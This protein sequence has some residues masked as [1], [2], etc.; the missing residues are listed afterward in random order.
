MEKRTLIFISFLII[1]SVFGRSF[2]AKSTSDKRADDNMQ[3]ITLSMQKGTEKKISGTTIKKVKDFEITPTSLV[4]QGS[5]PLQQ[6]DLLIESEDTIDMCILKVF[7]GDELLGGKVLSSIGKGTNRVSVFLP[8]PEK[9]L[10]T[11]WVLSNSSGILF[12]KDLIWNTPRHWTIYVI[13]SSHVDIGLHDPQY[14][15]RHMTSGLIDQAIQLSDNTSHWPDVSRYRYVVEGLWWWLNY[16]QDRSEQ[17]GNKVVEKYI[18]S[19]II[20][21]GAS[22]SGNHTQVYGMEELCRSTY[23]AQ[24]VRNRWGI[25]GE[26]M[27]VADINGIS[28]PLVTAYADAGIKN[29]IFLPNAWNALANPD[30]VKGGVNDSRVTFGAND[31]GVSR[32]AVGWGSKLPH[33]FYWQGANSKSRILVWTN[34][35]YSSTGYDFGVNASSPE[36]GAP[37]MV[38]QLN[39]LESR[40]PYN[41]WLASYYVDN[42]KPNNNFSTLAKEWNARW[43]WP[44]LRT[45]GD[46]SEPF[47]EVEKRSGDKIPTLSGA[48]TG[49]WAQHPVSTPN[50]LATKF[51]AD[52][53]LPTAE[54]LATLARLTNPD[55]IYPTL[56]FRRAWDALVCNDEHGYGTSYYSGRPVYDTWMQKKDWIEQAMATAK[57]E[58]DR[59]LKVL[60]AQVTANTPS[61]FVFNPTLLPRSEI[62]KINIPKSCSGLHSVICPDG[63]SAVTTVDGDKLIFKTSEIPSMGYALFPLSRGDANAVKRQTS[64]KPPYIEN[65]FYRVTFNE[66]GAI[67]SIFDKQLLRELVDKS[68]LYQC[69]QFVYTKDLHKNFSSPSN[70]RFEIETSPLEQTVIAR[71]DDPVSGAAI[72][73]RVTLPAHEKRID[74]DNRLNHVRDLA[75]KERW[76]RFGYYAFPFNVPQGK[77]RIGLNGCNVDPYEDQTGL[78]TDTYHAARDWAYIGNK[79]FGVALVQY[80]SQLIECGKIHEKKNTFGERPTSSHLYS[81]IFNDWLYGHA[82]V[83]GPSYINLRYRYVIYSHAGNFHDANVAQFAERAVAPVQTTVI[84]KAQKGNRPASPFSF[85]SVDRPNV[86]LL[87]LKLSETPGR[88]LI[89]RFHET[90]GIPIDSMNFKFD[91]VEDLQ[92][93]SCSITEEDHEIPNRR[94]IALSPFDYATVRFEERGAA[95]SSPKLT[96]AEVSDKT[97]ELN[98]SPVPNACQYNLYRGEYANFVPDQY[99]LMATTCET[100]FTDDWL[101][102]GTTYYYRIAAVDVGTRQG[103]AS[104]EAQGTTLSEGNSPPAK[105]GTV[106]TGLISNPRAWRGDTPDLLYLQW[107]QNQETDLSHYELFR[108][109]SPD[110]ELNKDSFVAKVIPGPYVVVPFEDKG[111]KQNTAYYYRVRAVDHDGHKGLPSEVFM[112]ITRE[113]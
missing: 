108:S 69:N 58:S 37:K 4:L 39:L 63:S 2:P 64:S 87:T 67:N 21:V 46:L 77:F 14:K 42:E 60:A 8:E 7:S 48:I 66:D 95:P 93:T 113:P 25:E 5:P 62:V 78:G 86:S 89:A 24:E 107:G 36:V 106:Y 53:F 65:T 38:K 109:E 29:L 3:L 72:E 111:L 40:Y 110:F 74:I 112:G 90:D 92:L 47:R 79:E 16:P 70:A 27:I 94:T 44:E 49:G 32:I 61:V 75:S 99:H 55:Y 51:E 80:D 18:R 12:E 97:V 82:Y 52:R 104:K 88:G 102:A 59:A 13:K 45:V 15:Q 54:K 23:Y 71:M 34:P 11:R 84:Q 68:A 96:I 22:H 1:S 30:S 33:L 31:G 10:K 57:K 20:G 41:I 83:T 35:H 50:L 91:W 101:K 105:V 17:V 81:Y 6:I 56:A 43:R 26:T 76:H 19:G 9:S 28:W 100:A 103:E 73:Q 85:L 98:W